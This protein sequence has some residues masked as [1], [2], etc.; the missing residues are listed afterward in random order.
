MILMKKNSK[1]IKTTLPLF[2]SIIFSSLIGNHVV[3]KDA[4]N[5][6]TATETST[7]AAV[8]VA[9]GTDPYCKITP[10]SLTFK[11]YELGLC[12]SDAVANT[13]KPL[14]NDTCT[15]LF[16][17]AA[18]VDANLSAGGSVD[19]NPDV[20]LSEGTYNYAYILV[21]SISQINLSHT[22]NSNQQWSNGYTNGDL[23]L[24]SGSGNVCFTN[25]NTFGSADSITCAATDQSVATDSSAQ[26][27]GAGTPAQQHAV[28][29]AYH[30]VSYA[31]EGVTSLTRVWVLDADKEQ[32]AASDYTANASGEI[33]SVSGSADRRYN[34]AIQALG[35]PVVISPTTTSL[36]V[37]FNITG[38][39]AIEF[40]PANNNI[41][42]ST[43]GG[44][45]TS[46][47]RDL[48][49]EGMKFGFVAK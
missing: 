8:G 39:T 7:T 41:S 29:Y 49:F 22:F 45:C 40:W 38:S 27:I 37:N 16:T 10:K 47:I 30:S 4:A 19:L 6:C 43:G 9:A 48:T 2:G 33:T 21:K 18:G 26:F 13:T 46:C 32:S 42:A 20:T 34:Y 28:G 15:A 12:S 17:S 14:E 35:N 36:A 3:A 11:M 25:G 1:M 24:A 23:D 44:T 31:V 5:F